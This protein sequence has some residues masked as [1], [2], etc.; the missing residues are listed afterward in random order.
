MLRS[1]DR[2][3]RYTL[4]EK[5]GNGAFGVVWLADRRSAITTT[6]VAI[7]IS[8]DDDVDLATIEREANIWVAA[9][10]HPNVIPIIEADIIDGHLIIVSE[11]AKDGTLASWLNGFENRKPPLETY[12][13]L[14]AGILD[15]LAHLHSKGIIHRDLKPANILFQGNIPR[16][17]DFG[18]SSALDSATQS[19]NSAGTPSYMA[20]EAF[21]GARTVQ[22]DIWSVGVIMYEILQGYLPFQRNDFSST[23]KA[24]LFDEPL[25]T[26]GFIPLPLSSMIDRALK[27]DI[28][29]RYESVS[30]MQ[31]DIR[32]KLVK[33]QLLI[34][35]GHEKPSEQLN[36]LVLDAKKIARVN[37]R[38]REHHYNF[39]HGFLRDRTLLYPRMLLPHLQCEPES[40]LRRLGSYWHSSHPPGTEYV[41]PDG[42]KCSPF[43]INE[44]Y[45]SY[46]VRLPPAERRGEAIFVAILIPMEMPVDWDAENPDPECRYLTLEL[47]VNGDDDSLET[48]F[49]EWKPGAHFNYGTGLNPSEKEFCKAVRALTQL[50]QNGDPVI[51]GLTWTTIRDDSDNGYVDELKRLANATDLSVILQKIKFSVNGNALTLDTPEAAEFVRTLL[52]IIENRTRGDQPL[53]A[54][55]FM[56]PTYITYMIEAAKGVIDAMKGKGRDPQ[57]VRGFIEGLAKAAKENGTVKIALNRK[58][59]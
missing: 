49:C 48:V 14:V 35:P 41:A 36:A 33:W 55:L 15:G 38:P 39:G 30:E 27:K 40:R 28:T 5:L 56:K 53:F 54:A 22:T 47:G 45:Y 58:G 43:Q 59:E 21:D 2:I 34:E 7:K 32:S 46:V 26:K 18:I 52:A 29:Q 11:F 20:P 17:A 50:K 1:G 12:V 16:L 19:G 23:V 13:N 25:P 37:E 6:E 3:G 51:D 44:Q 57:A 24:I 10:G 42:L 9:S 8:L 4:K 31:N